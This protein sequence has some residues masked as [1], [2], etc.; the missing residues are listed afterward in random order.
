MYES[1][2]ARGGCYSKRSTEQ[3]EESGIVGVKFRPHWHLGT[4]APSGSQHIPTL[5]S[6]CK[7]RLT[8]ASAANTKLTV[9]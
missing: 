7:T 5:D 8:L 1:G 4:D 3:T 2:N 6:A 9:R